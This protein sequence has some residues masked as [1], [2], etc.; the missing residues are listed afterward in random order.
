M[1]HLEA[2]GIEPAEEH[3]EADA[4]HCPLQTSTAA[5]AQAYNQRLDTVIRDVQSAVK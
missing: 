5:D 4:I 3:L 2:D 1:E